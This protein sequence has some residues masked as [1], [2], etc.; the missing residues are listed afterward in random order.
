[1]NILFPRTIDDREIG[2]PIDERE[3]VF[4]SSLK[5][6]ICGHALKRHIPSLRRERLE[7]TSERGEFRY[8]PWIGH[9]RVLPSWNLTLASSPNT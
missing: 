1:M 9:G 2:F 6:H 4:G 8:E 5:S 3:A 7:S